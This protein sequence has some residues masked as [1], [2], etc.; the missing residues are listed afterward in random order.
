LIL[1]NGADWWSSVGTEGTK[2]TK[3]FCLTGK[4]KN[5]GLL[6]VPLGITLREIVYDMGGG[7]PDGKKFKAAQLGG[8]SGGCVPEKYLDMPIDFESLK[9]I[10]SMMGSGGVVILDEDS[11][12]VDTARFF[13]EFDRDESCGK[14]LPCRKGLPL[15]I[16][17]LTKITEGKGLLEDLHTLQNLAEGIAKTALC[18]LGQTAANPTLSTIRHFREEYE[19]HIIKKECPALVCRDLVYFHIHPE[20]CAGC[21][22]CARKCPVDAI[23]GENKEVHVIDQDKCIKCGTCLEVCPP[24]FGAVQKLTGNKDEI[25]NNQSTVIN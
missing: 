19:A 12:M 10:G 5:T 17:I 13:L 22:I 20:K 18:A 21:H 7:I 9:D 25:L 3:V 2:G 1:L 24:R 8:P 4:I 14:C 11:C 15:M 23:Y 6:E 16:E